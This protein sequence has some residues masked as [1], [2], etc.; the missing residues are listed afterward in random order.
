MLTQFNVQVD[1]VQYEKVLS[2]IEHGKRQGATLLTG[3]KACGEK[4]YYIE[5]TIFTDVTVSSL[6][7]GTKYEYMHIYVLI[8]TFNI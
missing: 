6:S 1:K 8:L 5:P 4:G 2:Y 7:H 3:G